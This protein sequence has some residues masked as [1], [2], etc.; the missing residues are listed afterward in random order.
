MSILKIH[1]GDVL[2]FTALKWQEDG[3]RIKSPAMLLTPVAHLYED[4]IELDTVISEALIDVD[5][6]GKLQ[7]METTVFLSDRGWN[8]RFLKHIVKLIRR[9]KISSGGHYQLVKQTYRFR[10]GKN[11]RFQCENISKRN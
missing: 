10:E 9:R 4:G 3:W 2:T 11:G 6:N 1:N 7:D 5:V 8:L